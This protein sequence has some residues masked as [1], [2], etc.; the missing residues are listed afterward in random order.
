ML[1][2]MSGPGSPIGATRREAE[3]AMLDDDLWLLEPEGR[4][5]M[6]PEEAVQ[7]WSRAADALQTLE[8]VAGHVNPAAEQAVLD[9]KLRAEEAL[10]R[11]RE[12]VREGS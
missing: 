7:E 8:H 12:R 9:A 3:L 6:E 1:E 4:L 10:R 11:A 2:Y 5:P